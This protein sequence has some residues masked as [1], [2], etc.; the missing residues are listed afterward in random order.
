MQDPKPRRGIVEIE[1]GREE[2]EE[3]ECTQADD[4]D[5]DDEEEDSSH[6]TTSLKTNNQTDKKDHQQR[7]HQQWKKEV[8]N[9]LYRLGWLSVLHLGPFH[10]CLSLFE[11][12]CMPVL[13]C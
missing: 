4:D 7:H 8:S 1:E 2:E 11:T 10:P 5:E 9:V 3:E 13:L 12:V 6:E